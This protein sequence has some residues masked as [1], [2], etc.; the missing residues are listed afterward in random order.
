MVC[1]GGVDS[2]VL[3]AL[4]LD[5]LPS[6]TN[7][8]VHS[9]ASN[10]QHPDIVYSKCIVFYL[11]KLKNIH[12]NINILLPTKNDLKKSNYILKKEEGEVDPYYM[13]MKSV[14]PHTTEII[15]GDTIDEQLGGY[16]KHIDEESLDISM[17]QLIP[18]HLS[19]LDTFSS[20]FG[21]NVFLPY[22]SKQVMSCSSHFL[23]KELVDQDNRKKPMRE[24]ARKLQIPEVIIE[25]R[26]IGL[27]SAMENLKDNQ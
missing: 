19:V 1:S 6:F 4:L 12:H 24:L 15:C 25:R 17:E 27:C 8:I 20:H 11:H 26:K 14:K 18:N 9:I 21:I 10:K 3:L 7:I 2:S 23:F 5:V 22:G 13:L 16:Y